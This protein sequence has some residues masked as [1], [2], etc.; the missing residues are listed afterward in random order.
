MEL[1]TPV[2]KFHRGVSLPKPGK[3][4]LF[5]C[6]TA[7]CAQ[8]PQSCPHWFSSVVHIVHSFIH[9]QS[10]GFPPNVCADVKNAPAKAGA[11]LCAVCHSEERSDRGNLQVGTANTTIV[12]G[13][14]QK[15]NCPKGKRSHPGV[16]AYGP[17]NS[18][19]YT[20]H[21]KRKPLASPTGGGGPR[22]GGGGVPPGVG[23]SPSQLR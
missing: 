2:D 23:H 18:H 21:D 20:H 19:G 5:L 10:P 22:S 12:P 11:L 17:R 9:S 4:R 7:P 1:H 6:K 16:R 15:V 3:Y 8:S 13:D 14:C